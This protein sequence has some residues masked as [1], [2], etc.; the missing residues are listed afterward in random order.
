M[1]KE[2]DQGV[3]TADWQ[4]PPVIWRLVHIPLPIRG[5]TLDGG[6]TREE[7]KDIFQVMVEGAH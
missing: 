1:G 5:L 2:H 3:R 6:V 4:I 7:G